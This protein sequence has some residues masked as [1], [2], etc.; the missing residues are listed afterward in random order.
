MKELLQALPILSMIRAAFRSDVT[1][2]VDWYNE[3]RPHMTLKG[4][5]PNEVYFRQ[6]PANRQPRFEPRPAWP[7]GS[8][9]AAPQ[10]L[11]KGQPGTQI[12]M[13]VEFVNHRRHLPV[14]RLTRAA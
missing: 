6:R 1:R 8:P 4:A 9:C 14:V 5:T 10:C 3:H 11:V 12:Q 7:R 2:I 13:A